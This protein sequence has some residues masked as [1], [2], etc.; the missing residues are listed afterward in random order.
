MYINERADHFNYL[1][2]GLKHEQGPEKD[3][4]A[5]SAL[6]ENLKSLG[7]GRRQQAQ[8]FKLMA[9]I[10]NLGNINFVDNKTNNES[11]IV[12]NISQLSLTAELLGVDASALEG[13]LT[14][15]TRLV[16]RDL[17]SVYLGLF[18]FALT[19]C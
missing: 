7:I 6:Q 17:I 1:H 2:N 12:K 5:F 14:F 19:L 8:L 16:R 11:C 15:K 18:M 10:L 3:A 9:A 13:V 4:E